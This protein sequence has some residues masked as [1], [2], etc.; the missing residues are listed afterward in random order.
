MTF[1][2]TLTDETPLSLVELASACHVEPA[3]IAE[4]MMAGLIIEPIPDRLDNAVFGSHA[5][6]RT[7]SLL[8]IER[9]FDANPELAALVVDLLDEVTRLRRQLGEIPH[10]IDI[11]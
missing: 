1:A 7:R 4:R 10:S 8:R 11:L 9:D 2:C 5:L 3:W 6:H